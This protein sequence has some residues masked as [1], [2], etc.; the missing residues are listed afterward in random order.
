[1]RS[2]SDI[3]ASAYAA[4]SKEMQRSGL[5]SAAQRPW[6][7]I[8]PSERQCWEQV[9]RQ[10]LAEA[11]TAGMDLGGLAPDIHPESIQHEVPHG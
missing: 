7:E 10:V 3:A 1:M 4:H 2:L 6:E 11:A 8:E 5:P 9:A